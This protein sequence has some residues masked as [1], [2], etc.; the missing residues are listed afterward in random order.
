MR[1]RFVTSIYIYI[2]IYIYRFIESLLAILKRRPLFKFCQI[3]LFNVYYMKDTYRLPA[4]TLGGAIVYVTI[5]I[6]FVWRRDVTLLQ[7]T[8]IVWLNRTIS[9]PVK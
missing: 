3:I 6:D 2:Y 5:V 4:E 7:L 9:S 8:R 1:Q